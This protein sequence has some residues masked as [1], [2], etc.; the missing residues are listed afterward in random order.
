MSSSGN[1]QI[2][3]ALRGQ[4][5]KVVLDAIL[6]ED[7]FAFNAAATIESLVCGG[8]DVALG[9]PTNLG[10]RKRPPKWP[11]TEDHGVD[12]SAACSQTTVESDR[13]KGRHGPPAGEFLP[14]ST[15]PWS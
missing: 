4:K 14:K 15:R 11:A 1:S 13:A 8:F 2:P 12:L 5:A 3:A 9:L 6:D 7:L 10:A